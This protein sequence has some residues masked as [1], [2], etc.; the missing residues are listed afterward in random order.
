MGAYDYGSEK[1]LPTPTAGSTPVSGQKGY[2][3]VWSDGEAFTYQDFPSNQPN[4]TQGGVGPANY[5]VLTGGTWHDQLEAQNLPYVIEFN[6]GLTSPPDSGYLSV[7]E[8]HTSS[9]L[10]SISAGISL[11]SNPG[12]ATVTN[13][14]A[15][16]ADYYDPENVVTTGH[17]TAFPF[18]GD[19]TAQDHNFAVQVQGT[20]QITTAGT[21]TFDV[22]SSDGFQ[23]TINGA[24]FTGSSSGTTYS[25]NTM[26]YSN[27]RTDRRLA[28]RDD[29]GRGH[30]PDQPV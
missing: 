21:Y 20:I 18:G 2:G 24:T 16:V 10:T 11:I 14:T 12:T 28:G 26:T 23:L 17:F 9:S 7:V 3:F 5:V 30:V 22:T 1:S 27:T 6:L 25:G 4:D 8:A 15:A 13:Y 29:A 19:T